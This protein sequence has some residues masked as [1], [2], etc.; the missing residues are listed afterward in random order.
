MIEAD[1][2][3]TLLLRQG[4]FSEALAMC[5][6]RL[7]EGADAAA[8]LEHGTVLRMLRRYDAALAAYDRAIA[9]AP[10]FGDP[11][12]EKSTLL[13]LRGDYAQGWRLY[14][15][16]WR[17]ERNK[18]YQRQLASPLW[19]GETPIGGKTILLHA[20]QGNGDV[21]QFARYV[22]MVEALGASVVLGAGAPLA[23][24]LKSLPGRYRLVTHTDEVPVFD[25]HAPL[26]SL[27]LAFGTRADTIPADVPY[28][29]VDPAQRARWRARLGPK[30]CP[31]IGLAWSGSP[32]HHSDH[33]R[34]LP[35]Q[36]LRPLFDL[37]AEFHSLQKETRAED[38]ATLSNL[39]M[40]RCHEDALADFADTAALIDELDLVIT[41]DTAVAHLAGALSRPVWILLGYLHD[42][43]WLLERGDSP[44]YPTARLFRQC[45]WGE[46]SAVIAEVKAALRARGLD[47][48]AQPPAALQR[49]AA[50]QRQGDRP[51]AAAAYREAL[52]ADPQSF[53]ALH[54]LAVLC[55]QGGRLAE[56][57]QWFDRALA[58]QPH[59]AAAHFNRG[60]VLHAQRR[61][62]EA[63][64]AY[65]CA[66]ALAAGSAPADLHHQ[67]GQVLEALGRLEAALQAYRRA[68][69]VKP[70][71]A[72]AH[73]ACAHL[74]QALQ[75]PQEALEAYDRGLALTPD[76]AV[77]HHNRAAVLE[78][79]GRH[80]AA[81]TGYER[82]VALQPG[83]AA[84]HS[85][86]GN[87]LRA[88]Q[89]Y[90]EALAAYDR[91]V[92]L[93]PDLSDAYNHRGNVL[94]MLHRY[95]AALTDY[96]RAIVLHPDLAWAHYNK[97][98]L[99]LLLGDYGAGWRLYEW[100]WH[101]PGWTP[102][103]PDFA[104]RLWLGERPVAGKVLLLHAEQ[105]MG[106]LIQFVRYVP[107]V[108]ALGARVT[109]AV[110]A[111]L[112]SLL[113]GVE[114]VAALIKE[115]EALPDFDL[116]CP[117]MSLPLALHNVL[118]TIPAQ[119]PYLHADPAR[120]AQWRARLGARTRPRIG[121]VW[122][123][124]PHHRHD[125]LRSLPLRLLEP[126]L[127]AD[128]EFHSLQRDL[129]DED[130]AVLA[131]FGAI[132]RHEDALQDFAD[133]AALIAELDRIITVDTAVAH[134]AGALGKPVWVLLAHAPDWRWLLERSDSPWYPTARLFRQRQAGDWAGVIAEVLEAEKSEE[135]N[136]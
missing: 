16:R 108:A 79:L 7:A 136:R 48:A 107:H 42:Y 69:A 120:R 56:A 129:R 116:H 20:E 71:H 23:P 132:R 21:I 4:R 9:L 30:T 73:L 15:W 111:T 123:G 110:P 2:P 64:T 81:L 34:S 11:Y 32:H 50:A 105:G 117:L 134:L 96:D 121:L 100:R 75:R 61:F 127:T 6:R 37:E 70:D 25:C 47:T 33:H 27:P 5:E 43:R 52:D 36:Q 133:T 77:A 72:G 46:W 78:A 104:R 113:A 24:L 45:A 106:D 65:D 124:N 76:E 63:L 28:L 87:C 26:M 3:V 102:R 31:R 10:E 115:G 17:T 85:N 39:P 128:A 112:G 90:D 99:K 101:L 35:L 74:L 67:R 68:A 80:E 93:Q 29:Y 1:N 14:E 8:H 55:G 122:S 38:L 57:L 119:V 98:L 66:V 54:G 131:E 62:E 103:L 49:A 91:A 135:R 19:L 40:L 58:V 114:G 88:L 44:W 18:K 13:L 109:L 51:A 41:V 95:A 130:A 125:H 53:A 59:S 83:L 84:S 89:R 22:P 92:A 94:Q 118:N 12:F 126:L 82:A 60:R 86:R 97:A